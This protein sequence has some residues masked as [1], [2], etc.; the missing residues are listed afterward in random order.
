M[1]LERQ[2]HLNLVAIFVAIDVPKPDQ[3]VEPQGHQAP[4]LPYPK[5]PAD[6]SIMV[7]YP[8][9]FVIGQINGGNIACGHAYE[10]DAILIDIAAKYWVLQEHLPNFFYLTP[11]AHAG[12]QLVV[13]DVAVPRAGEEGRLLAVGV[14]DQATH[15]VQ[16]LIFLSH[17][18]LPLVRAVAAAVV[19]H[20]FKYNTIALSAS[21]PS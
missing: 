3:V 14:P 11:V 21:N 13:A 18:N 12:S 16:R 17:S 10:Q 20:G 19:V 9:N 4:L 6:R 7:A 5:N 15:R 2:L 8:R 1:S